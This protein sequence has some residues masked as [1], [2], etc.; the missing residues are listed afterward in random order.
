MAS[1]PPVFV[2]FLGKSTGVKTAMRDIKAELGAT[3][4]EGETSFSKF[5]R[6]GGAALAG[7]GIAAAG[8]AV[9]AVK[10][11]AD[12][13]TQMTRVRTGA[14]ETAGNMKMVG[15]G[16]LAMA[17]QV[18]QSTQQLTSG[19]YLVES[20]GFHGAN[21]LT[22]LK[23]A[24]QGAKV[25][26]AD[27]G[28]TA[29]AV[30]TAMNAYKMSA[31]QSTQAMNA[32]IATE[33][34]GK[35]NLEALAGSMSSILPVSAAAHVGLNE[36]LG[37]MATMTAQGT[38]A[39]VAA[40]YLRQT[41]GQLS[42][43][44][45][46]AAQEMQSLGL[47]A[48]K[49]SQNL[50]T[51]GL[52]S[53]LNMLTSAIESKMGPAG[54]V[55][56][57]H[58]QKAAKQ[59][60]TFQKALANLPPAQQTY[61]GALATMVGGTKSM[62]AALQLTGPHMADFQKNTETISEHVKA[63]GKNI[64]GWSDVQ[65]T[66]NQR[67]A[68]AKASMQ[69]MTIQVGQAL[70]PVVTRMMGIIAQVVSWLTRHKKVAEALAILIGTALVA[71]IVAATVA[72]YEWI[73]SAAVMEAIPWVAAITVIIV[74]ILLLVMHWKQVWGVIKAV[75]LAVGHALVDFWHWL[76]SSVTDIWNS[77]S[78]NVVSA[79][80]SIA[81]FFTSAWH[82]VVDPIV[83]AWHWLSN[84]TTTVWNAITGFFKKWWPLLLVI[85][86]P[87]VALIMAIWNHFHKQI[88]SVV[89]TVWNA[90]KSFLK[91]VWDGIKTV[92]E[93]AWKGI[94]VVIVRPMET[95][96]GW[97]KSLWHTVSGWLSSAWHGIESAASA[98]WSAI[99]TAMINPLTSAWHS[100]TSTVGHIAS[101]ISS[102]L[103]GAWNAVKNVGSW[104]LGIG[105]SIVEGIINGVENMGGALFD[106][107]KNLA[108]DA[109]SSA[110]SFL[111]INSPSRVFAD[112]VGMAIPEGIAKGVTDHAH[113]AHR[114]VGALAGSLS[115][116]TV[117][118]GTAGGFSA[119]GYAAGGGSG[120]APVAEIT[121]I[122]QVDKDVLFKVQQRSTL[123]YNRRNLTNGMSL[124]RG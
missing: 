50:G 60:N 80:H 51:H 39:A 83:S 113:L 45:G 23:T 108:S 13:Q 58:L 62:Q 105:K 89:H 117:S 123:Q 110:K 106:S 104:F 124:A 16:V 52:A 1:L 70:L 21:A 76:A 35:T 8:A 90:I 115:A 101:A 68:E 9:G 10:M 29:D 93:D 111:G 12:F 74:V 54:T 48:I 33:G 67:V 31:S 32:L 122:A 95:L 79:W 46:K 2:E 73:T 120:Q 36:V 7:I 34:A 24:A 19:L 11:A 57:E 41:I 4:A 28:T 81:G 72:M 92:A 26:A 15:D 5:G 87:F 114:A 44:S 43:P 99:K 18:G 25:G 47:S 20:A 38:P 49:V 71:A 102:G 121:V 42:N 119:A 84:I 59:S 14:G 88:M 85:F 22:V 63:G 53:T 61:I 27:L 75:G 30:T 91:V 56:I 40:T 55:L 77:I 118:I 97:L 112:H 109:L 86:L 94:Q 98:I 103:H 78:S 65:K 116:Q 3:A 6:V 100:I 96:W 37:A 66:F 82:A 69:A 107:L 64:E 17:G